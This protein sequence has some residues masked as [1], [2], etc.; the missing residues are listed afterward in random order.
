MKT[1]SVLRVVTSVIS[2]KNTGEWGTTNKR[3]FEIFLWILAVPAGLFP[4]TMNN[5]GIGCEKVSFCLPGSTVETSHE[6]ME[7]A[8]WGANTQWGL[9]FSKSSHP[10]GCAL[11]MMIYLWWSC[12]YPK[13][14]AA[15]PP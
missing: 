3:K 1:A 6:L 5:V 11:R 12:A 7:P 15:D 4:I 8:L 13:A 2:F 9:W 14:P 10:H